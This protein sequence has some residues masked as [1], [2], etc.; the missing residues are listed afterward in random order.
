MNCAIC[1]ST[2]VELVSG[3]VASIEDASFYRCKDCGEEFL[4]SEQS[5]EVSRRIKCPTS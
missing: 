1:D 5:K 4:T 2:N 3:K